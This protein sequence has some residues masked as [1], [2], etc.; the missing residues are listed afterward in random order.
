MRG[1]AHLGSE[2]ISTAKRLQG[3][4]EMRVNIL[5]SQVHLRQ[6]RGAVNCKPETLL[7]LLTL[8]CENS[9]NKSRDD[10]ERGCAVPP[11]VQTAVV[12]G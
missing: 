12:L 10:R 4:M 6:N 11:S 3:L 8:F 5:G 9:Q 2:W 1:V 7:F